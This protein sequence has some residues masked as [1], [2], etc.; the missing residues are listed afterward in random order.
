MANWFGKLKLSAKLAGVIIGVSLVGL[1]TYST[2]SW[3]IQERTA[4]T[5][6]IQDWTQE[7]QQFGTLSAA[8]VK[9]GQSDAV[10]DAY[11]HYRDDESLGLMGFM[12]VNSKGEAINTWFRDGA[13]GEA[14]QQKAG[15]ISTAISG[16]E[17]L[18]S[19][20]GNGLVAVSVPLPLDKSGNPVGAITTVWSNEAIVADARNTALVRLASQAAIMALVVIVFLFALSRLMSRPLKTLGERI[21]SLREGDTES[22]VPYLD[23]DDEIGVVARALEMFR[24]E[25]IEKQAREKAAAEEREAV[26]LERNRNAETAARTAAM[27]ADA[28]ARLALALERLAGGDFSSRIDDLGP[29]FEKVT[30]DFNR[31][32][33]SVAT[34]LDDI[35]AS[36][37]S[38]DLG[39]Q[40][41]LHS[42][43][44]LSDRTARQ[45]ASL[46]Q[47]AAS[48]E[49]IT[50]TVK[51][52]SDSATQAGELVGNAKSQAARSVAKMQDAIGAMGRIEA[53]SSQIERIIG[54]IDEIAFQT[55]LLA[56]NAGVEAARAGE[57]GK[58]FAVVAQEVRELAQRSA[59]AAKEIK[60]LIATS[61]EEVGT[62]AA[63][64]NQ[65]GGALAEIEQLIGKIHDSIQDFIRSYSEQS[66]GLSEINTAVGYMDQV[67]QQNAAMA[68]EAN[69][70]SHDLV[71]QGE[72]LKTAVARFDTGRTQAVL[73]APTVKVAAKPSAAPGK[74]QAKAS[75]PVRASAGNTALAEDWE[76]F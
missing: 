75:V 1:V 26:S 40:Q 47:T 29:E 24:T 43:E 66:A 12:A 54:V 25:T 67:T 6:A 55:N 41:L 52:S 56:L 37:G 30:A 60:Q 4:M 17:R 62:G 36:A 68:Q 57:A 48:L 39:S 45:A 72:L 53:S 58:G 9:W 65:T 34:V 19:E 11:K 76:E 2:A 44:Q 23:N 64:V 38:I 33:D 46:E 28:V 50:A 74:P 15:T 13:V 51:R 49:Q 20:I 31:M 3:V 63:L 42:A 22:A 59:E 35:K 61:V 69:A 21:A 7:S 14:D 71:S 27:Q 5:N 16:E 18:V 10:G 73:H 32:V 8:A 70:A